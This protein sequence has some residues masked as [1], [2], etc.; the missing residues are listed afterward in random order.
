MSSATTRPSRANY[1]HTAPKPATAVGFADRHHT[2]MLPLIGRL[3]G[4]V[5]VDPPGDSDPR[6]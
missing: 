2:V 6:A 4:F 5:E 3:W 1:L